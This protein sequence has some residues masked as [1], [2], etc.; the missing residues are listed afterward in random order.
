MTLH[1]KS[2]STDIA[3]HIENTSLTAE[4]WLE[5]AAACEREANTWLDRSAE[6]KAKAAHLQSVAQKHRDM[7]AAHMRRK[8]Q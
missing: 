6:C 3:Q 2:N 8:E 7:A 4:R 5:R 1:D